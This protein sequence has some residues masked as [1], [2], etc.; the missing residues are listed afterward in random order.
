MNTNNIVAKTDNDKLAEDKNSKWAEKQYL[1]PESSVLELFLA[2]STSMLID[3]LEY[4][5]ANNIIA[6]R[7]KADPYKSQGVELAKLDQLYK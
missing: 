5:Y 4:Q 3:N 2:N 1:T 6:S 7:N